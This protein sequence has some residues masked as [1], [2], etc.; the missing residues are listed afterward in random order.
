MVKNKGQNSAHVYIYLHY[1]SSPHHCR[2]CS[3]G[4]H[5]T[6]S[7]WE[8][9]VRSY[10]GTGRCHTSDHSHAVETSKPAGNLG[11]AFILTN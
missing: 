7:G 9:S 3:Q 10:T 8:Y 4:Q 1:H 11:S 5:H 2:P 6:A